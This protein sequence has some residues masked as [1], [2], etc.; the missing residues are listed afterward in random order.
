M[1]ARRIALIALACVGL[2]AALGQIA[3]SPWWV[4]NLPLVGLILLIVRVPSRWLPISG[5]M[6]VGELMW[7]TRFAQPLVACYVAL[8][9]GVS[10]IVRQW[11]VEDPLVFGVVVAL[12]STSFAVL[13]LWLEGAWSWRV[14]GLAGMHVLLTVMSAPLVAALV[15]RLAR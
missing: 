3:P 15:R 9:G 4:P 14:A 12:A 10:L 11:D 1:P 8:G 5:L 7:M 2:H 13:C 6:A